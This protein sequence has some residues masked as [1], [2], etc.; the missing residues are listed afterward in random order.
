MCTNIWWY[1]NLLD[2]NP[3]HYS[4]C[5]KPTESDNPESSLG[6]NLAVCLCPSLNSCPEPLAAVS[7]LVSVCHSHKWC[8]QSSSYVT[9]KLTLLT[10]RPFRC[11]L[12]FSTHCGLDCL[13]YC[14]LSMSHSMKCHLFGMDDLVLDSV[15]DMETIIS[16]MQ[17]L[18]VQ[19]SISPSQVMVQHM[20]WQLSSAG[21]RC[22]ASYTD[23][24]AQWEYVVHCSRH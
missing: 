20:H 21:S 3:K 6:C 13:G 19:I 10:S 16:S 7:M 24:V 1:I 12:P 5:F 8:G 23:T 17:R 9:D 2:S 4:G 14:R 15:L 11:H 18:G 22:S